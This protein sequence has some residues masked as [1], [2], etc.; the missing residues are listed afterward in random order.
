MVIFHFQFSTRCL[1]NGNSEFWFSDFPNL[2]KY[3]YENFAAGRFF[4]TLQ[5]VI[6]KFQEK[7]EEDDNMRSD[8]VM[9][10][11]D[12]VNKKDTNTDTKRYRYYKNHVYNIQ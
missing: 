9:M 6:I 8:D 2:Y 7:R 3:Y 12:D 11:D 5:P 4:S 1:E 10:C